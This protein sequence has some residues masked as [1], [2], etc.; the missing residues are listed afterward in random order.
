MNKGMNE[1]MNLF[2]K[3]VAT[4]SSQLKTVIDELGEMV[5]DLL[6]YNESR[7]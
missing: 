6:K 4:V 5:A 2:D 1:Q 7:K 3:D